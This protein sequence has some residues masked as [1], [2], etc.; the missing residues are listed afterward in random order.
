MSFKDFY[1]RIGKPNR[2][3]RCKDCLEKNNCELYKKNL[4]LECNTNE[5]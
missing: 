1:N 4:Q 2:Q 5:T 3:L